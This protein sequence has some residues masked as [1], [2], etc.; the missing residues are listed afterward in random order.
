MASVVLRGVNG[1]TSPA[2]ADFQY[3]VLR[4]QVELA[5]DAVKLGNRSFFKRTAR[6]LIE[7]TRIHHRFVEKKAEKIISKIIV[8]GNIFPAAVT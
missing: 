1:K 6:C 2:A 4:A 3:P 8:R 5:T 7:S